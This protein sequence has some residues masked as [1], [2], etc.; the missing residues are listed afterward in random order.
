MDPILLAGL[1]LGLMFVLI[2]LH[3]PL[4]VAMA[5]TGLVC[6]GLMIGF[7][8]ALSLF[9]T[10]PTS[11]LGSADLAVIPLFLLM[12]SFAAA[13]GLSSDL[14]RFAYAFVGHRPGGLAFATIGGCAAFGAV[15]GSS[16][17]TAATFGRVA[18][19]EMLSRGYRPSIAAGC[20]AAGGTLG[21]L[22]PPSVIMVLY[23][24]L[25]E[26]FIIALF[27]AAVLPGILAVALH[28]IAIE[29]YVR[30]YPEAAPAGPR[31]SWR[32]RGRIAGQCWGAFLLIFIV[33][34][35]I[36]GGVFTVAEAAAIGAALSFL[37][38]IYRGRLTRKVFW[39]VLGEAASNTGLIYV[40]ILGASI[41]TYF[42]TLSKAPPA[43]VD[44][45]NSA[46]LHR[47]W[48]MFFLSIFYIILGGI[49]DEVAAMIITLPFV[50]PLVISLGFDPVWFGIYNVMIIEIGMICPPIGINV[51]V[52]H[53]MARTIPMQEI[54]RGI[55]PFLAADTTRLAL[56]VAIPEMALILP[57][58]LGTPM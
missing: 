40:M 47:L 33:S 6:T 17:A 55:M 56:L 9:A 34:G 30:L 31:L 8:P 24:I 3:V 45:I 54:Y 32:E 42:I 44:A 27:I 25:T 35:G 41:L 22:I 39:E 18:M 43:I 36:Y 11:I 5:M 4:G 49:F 23:G 1:G 21:I 51:F 53:G 37:F 14:Y 13:A 48:I 20:C 38:T 12:G 16:V 46:G 10:E 58:I 2:A 52:I 50:F 26:Q 29:I 15:C 7:K 57:R 28:F 19:P